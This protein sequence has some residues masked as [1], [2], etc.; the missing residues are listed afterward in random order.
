MLKI[1]SVR[2]YRLTNVLR[3]HRVGTGGCKGR[4][5]EGGSLSSS[6]LP[7]TARLFFAWSEGKGPSGRPR[8]LSHFQVQ[9]RRGGA[10]QLTD[11]PWNDF[12]PCFLPNGRI[13]FVSERRGGYPALRRHCPDLHA[14]T[15]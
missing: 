14:C 15:P 5:L 3:T 12:D 8:E 13:V 10:T 11:G 1:R 7:M 6:S 9:R 2:A 4:K